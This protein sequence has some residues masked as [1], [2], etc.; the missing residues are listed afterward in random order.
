M[1]RDLTESDQHLVFIHENPELERAKVTAVHVD[2][3]D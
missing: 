2:I 1:R 3:V